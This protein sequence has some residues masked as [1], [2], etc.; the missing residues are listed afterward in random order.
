MLI[1]VDIMFPKSSNTCHRFRMINDF[2][3]YDDESILNKI[4]TK[5]TLEC[6][7]LVLRDPRGRPSFIM[8][9]W[10]SVRE[11]IQ[12][13]FTTKKF[14]NYYQIYDP[15]P[16]VEN[17]S[18]LKGR[19]LPPHLIKTNVNGL[20]PKLPSFERSKS[21]PKLEGPPRP[22]IMTHKSSNRNSSVF[23]PNRLDR[24]LLVSMIRDIK[25]ATMNSVANIAS[26]IEMKKMV[27]IEDIGSEMIV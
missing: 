6:F 16:Q 19:W 2:R 23:T 24:K 15:I 10:L 20:K 11:Q 3:R 1:L 22:L 18:K 25:Q 4:M 21:T 26:F 14:I 5:N 8:K 12:E 27:A 9:D 13:F 7:D 17:Q